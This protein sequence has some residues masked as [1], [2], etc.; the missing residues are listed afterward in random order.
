MSTIVSKDSLKDML[1]NAPE[2]KRVR[3]IGRALVALFDR[4]TRDEQATNDT[5]EHNNVGFTGGDARGGSLTA[6]YFLKHGKL[7][8]WQVERWMKVGKSGYPRLCKYHKQLDA[9]AKAK[10]AKEAA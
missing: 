3:I 9:I 4:Q 2:D 7:E 1:M 6:K 8:S 5:K 10:A